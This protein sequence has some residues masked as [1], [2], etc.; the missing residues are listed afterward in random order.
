MCNSAGRTAGTSEIPKDA[1]SEAFRCR[2]VIIS[3]N[4]LDISP[5]LYRKKQEESDGCHTQYPQRTNDT[6]NRI[7]RPFGHAWVR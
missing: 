1:I 2:N 5:M 3:L 4:Q 7:L 6:Q